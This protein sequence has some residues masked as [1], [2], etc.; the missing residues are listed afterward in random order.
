[1]QNEALSS[2]YN[3][4]SQ[5]NDQKYLIRILDSEV[6]IQIHKVLAHNF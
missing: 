2:V 6:P 5:L 1:L 3:L 4:C